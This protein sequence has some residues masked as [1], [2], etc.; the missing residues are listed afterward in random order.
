MPP[1]ERLWNNQPAPRA[2]LIR[3]AGSVASRLRHR[4]CTKAD[5]KRW[6]LY[7]NIKTVAMTSVKFWRRVEH[8]FAIHRR[9]IFPRDGG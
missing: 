9:C 5:R 8:A 2:E 7:L 3:S 6:R 1:Y 4:L